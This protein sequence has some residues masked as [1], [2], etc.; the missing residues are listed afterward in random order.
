MDAPWTIAQAKRRRWDMAVSLVALLR[1]GDVTA[2]EE[3]DALVCV[4]AVSLVVLVL[5]L[6]MC[7]AIT[8]AV[9]EA[10]AW[11]VAVTVAVAVAVAVEVQAGAMMITAGRV[12]ST[13]ACHS[14]QTWLPEQPAPLPVPGR[15]PVSI[16]PRR[17]PRLRRRRYRD[18]VFEG[19]E[20]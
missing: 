3:V 8:V 10:V 20:E 6:V 5:V 7:G 2:F 13:V 19:L 11:V 1:V 17:H 4:L 12:M 15:S 9:A 14:A 16:E 18:H